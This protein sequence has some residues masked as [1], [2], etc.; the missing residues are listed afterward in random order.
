MDF[1]IATD[2]DDDRDDAPRV[3]YVLIAIEPSISMSQQGAD[4]LNR[5]FTDL[6]SKDEERRRLA[7]YDLF[8]LVSTASRG[9]VLKTL[10]RPKLMMHRTIS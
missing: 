9:E 6:R 3:P 1:G 4:T 8:Q 7:A 2:E 10:P 5:T